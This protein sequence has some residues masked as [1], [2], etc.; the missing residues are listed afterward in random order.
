[1][2]S[3][4]LFLVCCSAFTKNPL[5]AIVKGSSG[6]GKSHLVNTTL[7]VFR[8]MGCVI[9]FSRITSA[10]LENM[11]KWNM[12]A[13]LVRMTGESSDSYN[14]RYELYR[15]ERKKTRSIDLTGKIIFVDELRGIQN[16]QAPK[17]LISEGRLRLG[18][19]IDGEPVEIEVKG[20]PSI[21]TTTTLAALED[22]EFENRILPIQIDES[23][24]QTRAILDEEA[25]YYEDPAKNSWIERVEEELVHSLNALKPFDTVNPYARQLAEKYPTSNIEARR[26]F[27]K[28]MALINVSTWLHQDQRGTAVKGVDLFFVTAPEDIHTITELALEPLRESLSG[29]SQKERAILDY[30]QSQAFDK[31]K[32]TVKQGGQEKLIETT[33]YASRT[34]KEISEAT[35]KSVR[36]SQQWVRDHLKR[37]LEEDVVEEDPECKDQTLPLSLRCDSASA[38]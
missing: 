4:F 31:V 29:V 23:E 9:E 37:L 7:R 28:L 33:I 5:S 19:V 27:R 24:D 1:V 26:D 15:D 18:T 8:R 20:T 21:I 14:Q 25:S 11:P 10:Y 34:I 17:L 6:A 32:E 36:R 2:P 30:L 35:K 13:K 12:A 22:P 3:H 16:A 38:A